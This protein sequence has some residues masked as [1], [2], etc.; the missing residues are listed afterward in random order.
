MNLSLKP[1]LRKFIEEKVSAGEYGSAEEVVEAGLTA[2]RQQERLGSFEAGELDGLLEEGE[3]SIR[4]EGTFTASEV[5][6][7]LRRK[8]AERRGRT[9]PGV[10]E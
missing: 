1:E 4:E 8:A 3:K 9:R 10:K 7:G 6:Q 2:L 5:F